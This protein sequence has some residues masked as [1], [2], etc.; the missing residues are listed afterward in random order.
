M[1]KLCEGRAKERDRTGAGAETGVRKRARKNV[2][3]SVAKRKAGRK[4]TERTV[5]LKS[6]SVSF[7]HFSLMKQLHAFQC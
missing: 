1:L 2:V 4:G 5:F 3:V 7:F 6:R